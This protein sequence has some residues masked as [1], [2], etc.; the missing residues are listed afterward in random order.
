MPIAGVRV[1]VVDHPEYGQ[2]A[3]RT[4]GGFDMAVNGGGPLTL[5]FARAGYIPVQ[6]TVEPPAQD[7]DVVETITMIPYD[8]AVTK[9][10]LAGAPAPVQARQVTDGDGT[11]R[12]TLLF[13]AGTTA[14]ATLDGTRWTSAN[15]L[16]VRATE[17]TIGDSGPSAMPGELPP[18]SA[19]TYAVEYSVDEADK[20][21]ATDVRFSKPVATYVDN[22]LDFPAGTPV[23]AG[24]YD[25][26]AGHWVASPKTA[27]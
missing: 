16:N 12:A 2:T 18:T 26:A 10:D 24:Y 15:T 19:Y 6:R 4:D 17:F 13:E 21:G 25:R 9:V 22:F 5:R 20:L 8:D 7:Y 1:T 27:S 23:P 3:T 14:T 11:R